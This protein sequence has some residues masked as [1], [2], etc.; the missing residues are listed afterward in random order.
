MS[1]ML[2]PP[3]LVAATLILVAAILVAGRG[4]GSDDYEYGTPKDLKGL[5]VYYLDTGTDITY[6]SDIAEKVNVNREEKRLLLVGSREEAQIA[7]VV[8]GS[9]R[10]DD[11]AAFVVYVAG[12]DGRPRLI[13]KFTYTHSKLPRL[14]PS[15]RFA[16][17]FAKLWR[18]TQAR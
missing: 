16:R 11:G 7:I 12:K 9:D 8:V 14:R 17:D 13:Q 2:Q 1:R 3:R 6:R 10:D 4:T 15:S 18:G 5:T